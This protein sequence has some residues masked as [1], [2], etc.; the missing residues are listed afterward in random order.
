MEF[1]IR[2]ENFERLEKKLK[3]IQNKC[4]KYG[5]N[6]SFSIKG[7]EFRKERIEDTDIF[8]I[9]KYIIIDV[10]GEAKVDGWE[11][12]GSI[13]HTGIEDGNIIKS[14]KDVEIPERF[15]STECVCEHCNTNRVRRN[16]FLIRN[17]ETGE[18]KQ[19]G[20]ACLRDYTNGL[21]AEMA[22]QFANAYE[23]CQSANDDFGFRPRAYFPVKDILTYASE[24]IGKMGYAKSEQEENS[25]KN[26]VRI[27]YCFD[28]HSDAWALADFEEKKVRDQRDSLAFNFKS[29][30]AIAEAESA[31][32]WILNADSSQFHSN[33][34]HNLRAIA[35]N[36][37]VSISNI[38]ILVALI[39]TYQRE[40]EKQKAIEERQKQESISEFIGNVGDRIS[41]N[42]V[43]ADVVTYWET[44]FGTTYFNKLV[45]VDGNIYIW[46]SSKSSVCTDI[47]GICKMTVKAHQEYNGAKQTEVQR[48][49]KQK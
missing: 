32:E 38:G 31:L 15:Y 17:T 20:K 13:E 9:R 22:A 27:H 3:T 48:V 45:D 4:L 47:I 37:Y 19:I 46:K 24:I 14:L 16:T 30:E 49:Q 21:S 42:V 44:D 23:A 28:H 43:S 33:F 18:F 36:D 6:F 12:V 25:T 40:I 10:E 35:K 2:E 8:V 7:E 1:K 34:L 5:N 26:L 41:V 29:D 11:F 39:P